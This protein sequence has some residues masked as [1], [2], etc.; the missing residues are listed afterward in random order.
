MSYSICQLRNFGIIQNDGTLTDLDFS[1]QQAAVIIQ[2]LRKILSLYDVDEY[3]AKPGILPFPD[4][5]VK[6]IVR[7]HREKLTYHD[8]VY[9]V[10]E[11][12]ES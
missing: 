11:E 1:Q 8:D 4:C 3:L 9:H 5:I 2:R 12:I 7:T 10:R 6:Q